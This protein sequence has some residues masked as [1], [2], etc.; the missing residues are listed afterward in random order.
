MK[1]N[2][3]KI[4][5][6]HAVG[7]A[8]LAAFLCAVLSSAIALAGDE[9]QGEPGIEVI[10]P[11]LWIKGVKNR[12][13]AELPGP[14]E[15]EFCTL[16]GEGVKA[17]IPCRGK[18]TLVWENVS[19]P[20]A[21]RHGIE[22]R[23][24][25]YGT[26]FRARVIHGFWT[27]LPPLVAIGLALAFRQVL[28]ALWASVWL[29]AFII[30]DWRP[31]V[32]VARSVDHY[33]IGA[34]AD[35]DDAAMLVF[36]I[37]MG[38]MIGMIAKSGGIQ[39]IVDIIARRA[40]SAARGQAATFLMGLFIFFDDYAN[41]II[42]GNAMRPI[43]DRLKISREKLS[44]IVDST[45]AP[46][47]SI[48]PIS[49][50]IGYEVGLIDRALDSIGSSQSGYMMFLESILYR[51][52]PIFALALVIMV[53][54]SGRDFGPM[55]R[56]ERRARHKGKPLRDGALPMAALEGRA[57]EPPQGAPRRWYNAMAPLLFVIGVTFCGL[58]ID[59][60]HALGDK[61]YAEAAGG[62]ASYGMWSWVYVLGQVFS[63]A[64]P[65]RVLAWASLS[66]CLLTVA[67]VTAQRI[68]SMGEAMRAWLTGVE[69]M[70]IAIV[71]LLFAW[72]LGEV[73]RD[74]H[75]A[76]WLT[77]SLAGVLSPR[78]LP[79]LTFLIACG[80]SFATGTSY[81]T[82]AILIPLVIPIANRLGADAGFP[83]HDLHLVM[84]GT[85]SSVLA[86]SVFGD[87]CSPISDT[88]IMSSMAS[89]ADHVDHVRTQ[90]PYA[91]LAAAAGMM[92]GDIPAAFGLSPFI[93][94]I[95]GIAVLALV[96]YFV[97]DKVD[98]PRTKTP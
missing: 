72:S 64:A 40:T 19:I 68:L 70:V 86:G 89:S 42:V 3:L 63:A 90:I 96:L 87:H 45:S 79:V 14:A 1:K 52:Y 77:T 15:V 91:V 44:Y 73:C 84:V 83:D 32:A 29:G 37:F 67:M 85:V 51:F 61:G 20:V 58:W 6:R 17:E 11:G 31:A 10:A 75:T 78:L 9:A 54:L 13:E 7:A 74:L 82:M 43:T 2:R 65:N 12:V 16:A 8:F 60:V 80:I 69:S 49:T 5:R 62:A 35:P 48:F 36:I 26:V 21:G 94:I 46:V 30:Y 33:I 34:M 24:G 81:G 23:A 4:S 28:S 18:K 56:A 59:G 66:G 97:G 25:S 92:A 39:G 27:I 95:V 38:G 76:E 22:V 50:W 57:M 55:K 41:T 53:A 93:C 71:V 88:T 98:L 47:A